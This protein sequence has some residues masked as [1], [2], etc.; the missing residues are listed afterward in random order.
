MA[1]P[2]APP[3]PVRPVATPD[4][5]NGSRD[6]DWNAWEAHFQQ[7]GVVNQWTDQDRASYLPLYLGENAQLF[8]QSLP[9]ATRNNLGQ[10]LPALRTRFAPAGQVGTFRAELKA[11]RQRQGEPLSD[12]CKAIRR[13]GRLDYPTLDGGVQDQLPR[14][15]FVDGLDSRELRM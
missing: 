14:D 11:R 4:K 6:A 15:Q 3:R 1:Q 2:L 13:L 12:F 8:Y 10:L 7:V 9:Q 5:F